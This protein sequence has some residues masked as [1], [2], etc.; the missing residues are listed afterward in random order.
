MKRRR[1]GQPFRFIYQPAGYL[2]IGTALVM[3][4]LASEVSANASVEDVHNVSEI[5]MNAQRALKD[6]AVI[7]MELS[8]H[9]HLQESLTDVEEHFGGLKKSDKLHQDLLAEITELETLWTGIKPKF[10]K[11]P[12]DKA[13]MHELHEL[14][15]EDFTE[16]CQHIADK[17]AEATDIKGDEH[18]VQVARLGMQSQRLAA[19]YLLKAWGIDDEHYNRVVQRI[20][21]ETEQAYSKLLNADEKFVSKEIRDTIKESRKDFLSFSIMAKSTSG[22]FIPTKA[23]QIADKLYDM[24]R[25]I[26]HRTRELVESNVSVL[27]IPIAEEKTTEEIF[28]A[29]TESVHVTGGI[30]S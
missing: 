20:L 16:R 5:C 30:K 7:G 17:L 11:K 27:F 18:I 12:F 22:R 24:L 6:Y 26:L 13:T 1:T 25:D 15:D 2:L 21:S 3:L 9:N 28:K 19:I 8:Y 23:T 10:E 14:I 29:M 4:L